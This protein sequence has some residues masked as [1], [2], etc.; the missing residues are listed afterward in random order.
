MSIGKETTD[1][2]SI[3]WSFDEVYW[4][5]RIISQLPLNSIYFSI[6]TCCIKSI[7]WNE[8]V[9]FSKDFFWNDKLFW[10][11]KRQKTWQRLNISEGWDCDFCHSVEQFSLWKGL[12][13]RM[14]ESLF[15]ARGISTV[16]T[17][18]QNYININESERR[19]HSKHAGKKGRK[20]RWKSWAD[21]AA[22]A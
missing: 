22:I 2:S 6:L 21:I 20:G 5:D 18:D 11:D 1:W 13:L 14:R 4:L 16:M 8:S 3:K 19:T 17:C 10:W 7:N 9:G 15:W 12:E